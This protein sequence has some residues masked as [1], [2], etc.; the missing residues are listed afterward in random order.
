VDTIV[1]FP[2][3]W[4]K[5]PSLARYIAGSFAQFACGAGAKS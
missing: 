5:M 4:I 1:G 2:A 3:N